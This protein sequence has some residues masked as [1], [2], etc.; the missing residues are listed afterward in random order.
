MSFGRDPGSG[1]LSIL[2]T[3][4]YYP[5]GL[6]HSQTG[7]AVYGDT[8]SPLNF[9][10]NGKELQETGMY[11]Y[12]ARF[13]MP[14]I[15]RWGVVDRLAAQVPTW[16]PYRYAYD[17]PIRFYDPTG[18]FEGDPKNPP[19]EDPKIH[20]I[21]P[22]TIYAFKGIKVNAGEIKQAPPPSFW[23]YLQQY[24]DYPGISAPGNMGVA[25]P[26]IFV[27]MFLDV[28][29]SARNFAGF[30][31]GS[32]WERIDGRSMGGQEQQTQAVNFLIST[33]G[34]MY[35]LAADTSISTSP[36]VIFSE[37]SNRTWAYVDNEAV[38]FFDYSFDGSVKIELNLPQ[39]LQGKGVGT[40]IF[41]MAVQDASTFHATWVESSIYDSG[42]SD[43]L[44]QYNIGIRNGLNPT[45]AAWSTW[46]G[47]QAQLNGFNS[48]KV[49][50]IDNGIK[51][52]F[53]K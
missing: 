31:H 2:D 30:H 40:K 20:E 28:L 34:S 49:S 37:G 52:T 51:A 48:V 38:G 41:N 12:G 36:K 19:V 32:Q 16:S 43:N 8:S 11:D 5:F 22:V 1:A 14:D 33:F 29:N 3:N 9:K 45:Q 4:A 42:I 10:Y 50:P 13:Y 18:M 47:K 21:E 26:K 24:R 27:N 6:N 7:L 23:D 17:N 39:S 44:L 46:S 35:G 15:G 53:S 25:N